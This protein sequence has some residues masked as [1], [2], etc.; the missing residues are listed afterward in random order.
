[1][2]LNLDNLKEKYNL[3]IN[4]VLHIGAHVGQEFKTYQR[5]GI[6]NVMFF[7]PVPTTFQKLKENVGD[8]AI[9]I[10]AAFQVVKVRNMIN[11]GGVLTSGSDIKGVIWGDV[12]GSV[13]VGIPLA[14]ILGLWLDWG[15]YGVIIAR[16]MDEVAKYFIF[17]YRAKRVN[18]GA[19]IEEHK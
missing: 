9:L 13:V 15:L 6:D 4:G 14:I 11:A 1:M 17:G 3:V 12:I 8:S 16:S 5:L 7:E 19:L 10:N 2:L 18:W